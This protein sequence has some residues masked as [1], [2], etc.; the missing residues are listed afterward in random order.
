[1][2]SSVKSRNPVTNC[3]MVAGLL[4]DAAITL[5]QIVEQTGISRTQLWHTRNLLQAPPP[6]GFG[7]VIEKGPKR[8]LIVQDWGLFD[9]K[10]LRLKP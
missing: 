2:D 4:T 9:P 7:M 8:T 3:L 6:E 5:D 10:K 1:M